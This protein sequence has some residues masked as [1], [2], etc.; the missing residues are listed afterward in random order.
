MK[1]LDRGIR[2]DDDYTDKFVFVSTFSASCRGLHCISPSYKSLVSFFFFAVL[3]PPPLYLSARKF[4]SNE[5]E[6]RKERKRE[7]EKGKKTPPPQIIF[8]IPRNLAA[9]EDF[10]EAM[11]VMMMTLQGLVCD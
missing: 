1:L 3:P 8:L 4:F 10:W 7:R 11:M 2:N 9:I 5:V 6:R